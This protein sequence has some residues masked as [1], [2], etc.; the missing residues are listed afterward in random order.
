M[1]IP[2]KDI[3]WIETSD[4]SSYDG[5]EC[6]FPIMSFLNN[7]EMTNGYSPRLKPVFICYVTNA[8]LT[9]REIGILKQHEPIGCRDQFTLNYCKEAGIKA[10]FNGCITSLLPTSHEKRQDRVILSDIEPPL[11]P[12]I[13]EDYISVSRNVCHVGKISGLAEYQNRA[14][15]LLELFRR[16]KLCITSR[17][18]CA[19]PSIAFGTPVIFAKKVLSS[20][21]SWIDRLVPVYSEN[22]FSSIDWCP[23]AVSYDE[24]KS[25]IMQLVTKRIMMACGDVY[26][27]SIDGLI[28][29]VNDFWMERT[30]IKYP[31]YFENLTDSIS[32]RRN[33]GDMFDYAFWGFSLVHES[34]FR[35]MGIHFPNATLTHIYE[36]VR[37]DYAFRGIKAQP[38]TRSVDYYDELIVCFCSSQNSLAKMNATLQEQGRNPLNY[39][40]DFFLE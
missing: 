17:L 2:E 10:Y 26:S 20:R 37:T 19:S 6:I 30:Q 27:E 24:Q 1:G 13:P 9:S 23:H 35:Y 22:E 12:Y 15:E 28:A 11:L 40:A 34:I 29:A 31:S 18:H 14:L 5:E 32:K 25:V 39:V 4:V 7:I 16:S 21:F 36:D 33:S 38:I 3:I 8:P